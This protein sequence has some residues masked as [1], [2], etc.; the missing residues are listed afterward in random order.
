MKKI[1]TLA[2]CL[3]A[4]GTMSA[5]K[6]VVDQAAKLSGKIDKI[7]DARTLI[8]Q[9]AANPET[10]AD[11]RTYY[12]AGKIEF[13]AF[14]EAI[15]KR[16]INPNDP[17][18]NMMDMGNEIVNGYNWF[19]KALSFD[20]IPNDK[21][22]IKPRFSKDIVAKLN[23][24]HNDYYSYGGEMY[25]NKH[26]Y[27]E[28]YNSFIIYGDMPS[29]PWAAKEV[30]AVPDSITSLA[31]YYAGI[32]AFSGNELN[33]ALKAFGKARNK[34]I[35]DPQSYV[36]EIACW[37]NLM[38]RDSTLNEAGKAA[39]ENIA[40]QGYDTF[41][42]SNP[43]FINNLTQALVDDNRSQ[44]AIDLISNQ[45]NVTPDQAFLYGLRAWVNDHNNNSEAAVEDYRKVASMPTADVEN[46]VRSARRIFAAG[47]NLWNNIEGYQPEARKNVKENYFNEAKSIANRVLEMDP[48]NPSAESVIEN[49]DYM[50]SL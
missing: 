32:A 12:V 25:N 24:H 46:L 45:I 33:A 11:A 4:A 27:P 30:Q 22:Q 3:A 6:A 37:Q 19:V 36:Y 13:D 44:E 29:Q 28:A 35:N 26:F 20:S 40:R 31:Y 15:K 1:L 43:L 42:V 14:D 38:Q 39:I 2:L 9:A 47:Q 50:L 23:G 16:A 7:G 41:G 8:G 21:G 5:Q 34:G 48:G 10:S 49:V 17:A 18:V